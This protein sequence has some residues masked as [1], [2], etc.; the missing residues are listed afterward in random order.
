MQWLCYVMYW[1]QVDIHTSLG[2]Q[3]LMP[4]MGT[5]GADDIGSLDTQLNWFVKLGVT[6]VH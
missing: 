1:I 2:N 5:C 3:D 6:H 4:L